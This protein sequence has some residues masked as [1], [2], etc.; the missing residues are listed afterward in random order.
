MDINKL[1]ELKVNDKALRIAFAG[2]FS[3]G[4]STLINA[5]IYKDLLK[6]S[7]YETT[8][9]TVELYN[10]SKNDPKC[11]TVEIVRKDGTVESADFKDLTAL[12]TTSSNSGLI[13]EIDKLNIF[14]HYMDVDTPVIML[15]TPGLNSI[16]D[17][18]RENALKSIISSDLCVYNLSR[19]R[20]SR[21]DIS[22][23]RELEKYQPN[24]IFCVG[25]LDS[26]SYDVNALDMEIKFLSSQ[27]DKIL[28]EVN[29]KIV[30]VS[31]LKA[32][33]GRDKSI[34][35]VYYDDKEEIQF[36]DR[37]RLVQESNIKELEDIIKGYIKNCA[38]VKFDASRLAMTA[39]LQQNTEKTEAEVLEDLSEEVLL[40]LGIDERYLAETEK[41]MTKKYAERTREDLLKTLRSNPNPDLKEANSLYEKLVR[42]YRTNIRAEIEHTRQDLL[43]YIRNVKEEEQR[44]DKKLEFE[45]QFE[46]TVPYYNLSSYTNVFIN[47]SIS[48][49]FADIPDTA[50]IRDLFGDDSDILILPS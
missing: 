5:L 39:V 19:P 10:V 29:Y 17:F 16:A 40:N 34:K 21:T 45:K 6:H 26:V 12:T 20:L 1:L 11:R 37:Q 38:Q 23:L 49:F 32:L 36:R 8:V 25:F 7:S 35:K 44:I 42:E 33:A 41:Y 28:P 13:S 50:A 18:H 27:I 9:I 30:R 22:F 46:S 48:D 14:M 15:D 47:D 31:A 4:K 43:S 24:F 2:E 3:S